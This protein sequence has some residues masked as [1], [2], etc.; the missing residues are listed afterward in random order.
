VTL[1]QMFHP[2]AGWRYWWLSSVVNG[3]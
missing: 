2:L 3:Q 1:W